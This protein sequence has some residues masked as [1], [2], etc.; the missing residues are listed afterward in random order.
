MPLKVVGCLLLLWVILSAQSNT[1]KTQQLRHK[2]VAVAFAEKRA[3]LEALLATKSLSLDRIE[4]FLRAYKKDQILEVWAKP[5]G[6][7]AV[8]QRIKT[9][10][11]CAFSGELGPKRAQG[12]GQIPEGFYQVNHFNPNSYFYLSLGINYP[13][14][15]DRL[16][17]T[18]RDP[19]DAIYIHGDCV[20][21]GCIPLTDEGIKELYTLCTE[22]RH[23]GQ[24]NIP[25]H[26]FP[27]CMTGPDWADLLATRPDSIRL[28]F[29]ENLKTGHDYFSTHQQ[30]P[31]IQV[32]KQG[33]YVFK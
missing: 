14:Q 9:Y 17:A 7:K 11:F 5:V 18:A 6:R 22:A 27:G 20:T 3:G 32:D 23:A 33:R 25:V 24:R 28:A 31:Q 12:D 10:P 4:V 29:W 16:L 2:R 21:I 19:G 26:I 1:F 15:S 30:L 13:N 8:F